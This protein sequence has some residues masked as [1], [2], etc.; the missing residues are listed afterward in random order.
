M[1]AATTYLGSRETIR[2]SSMAP[3]DCATVHGER[4]RFYRSGCR[5]TITDEITEYGARSLLLLF[6][7]LLQGKISLDHQ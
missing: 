7:L 4:M 2:L 1:R 6:F 5:Q 3:C